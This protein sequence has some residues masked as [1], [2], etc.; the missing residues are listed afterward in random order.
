MRV[1]DTSAWIE[2]MLDSATGAAIR[3]HI[4]QRDQFV[5]PTIVQHELSKWLLREAPERA[6]EI[7][8][9]T[10]RCVVLTL[11]TEI[12][13]HSAEIG[14]AHRLPTVD[15]IIYA[16]ALALNGDLVT[17]DAHFEGLPNVIYVPK[18]AA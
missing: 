6:D 9:V 13:L 4:P 2:W 12:A 5:V 17:C 7:L 8:S 15:A 11:T 18:K 1:V 10:Q 16:T 14:I 3:Q